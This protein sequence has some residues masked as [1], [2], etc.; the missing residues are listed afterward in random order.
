MTLCKSAGDEEP[1]GQTCLL[2]WWVWTRRC[3]PS[4]TGCARGW[5]ARPSWRWTWW[6]QSSQSCSA[7]S[8]SPLSERRRAAPSNPPRSALR[9]HPA[10]APAMRRVRPVHV[11]LLEWPRHACCRVR[12]RTRRNTLVCDTVEE[13]RGIAFGGAERH[14]VVSKDG[15]QFNRVRRPSSSSAG[16]APH[17][18]CPR[19][20]PGVS[21]A[22]ACVGACALACLRCGAG[23]RASSRAA[24]PATLAPRRRGGTTG[25]W[26]SS[27]SSWRTPRPPCRYVGPAA[28]TSTPTPLVYMPR[29]VLWRWGRQECATWCIDCRWNWPPPA[30]SGQDQQ[31]GASCVCGDGGAVPCAAAGADAVR[32][33]AGAAGLAQPGRVGAGGARAVQGGREQDGQG[34]VRRALPRLHER[35]C[36][37]APLR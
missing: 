26:A 18:H 25:A 14:K 33:A 19:P 13:A 16:S 24:T 36:S 29:C 15:T 30:P 23:R 8:S 17:V 1:R 3:T 10:Q 12:V 34:E 35:D 28:H 27:S 31:S 4:T 21:D 9:T 6:S 20:V 5:A 37:A 2:L 7:P 22:R 11:R 32:H